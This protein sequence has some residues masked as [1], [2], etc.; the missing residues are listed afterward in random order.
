[1]GLVK[2]GSLFTFLALLSGAKDPFEP[3]AMGP[4]P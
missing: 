3:R 2:F 4:M 1:M